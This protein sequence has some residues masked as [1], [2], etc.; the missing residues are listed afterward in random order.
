MKSTEK[1]F[2]PANKSVIKGILKEVSLDVVRQ[3]LLAKD[4]KLNTT[5]RMK[6][7]RRP[8]KILQHII[9]DGVNELA[10]ALKITMLLGFSVWTED[11]LKE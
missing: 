9:I 5:E 4:I 11:S 10:N 6:S 7:K 2:K 8:R 3:E 1:N